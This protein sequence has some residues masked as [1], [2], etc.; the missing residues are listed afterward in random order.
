MVNMMIDDVISYNKELYV[1]S[2]DFQDAFGSVPHEL[3]RYNLK[4]SSLS[5]DLVGVWFIL[6]LMLPL[7]FV[8]QK[9]LVMICL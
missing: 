9:G 1:I 3:L 5:K 4:K 8:H 2:L 7:I 6:V